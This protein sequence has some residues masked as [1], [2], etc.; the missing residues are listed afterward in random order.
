MQLAAEQSAREIER[1]PDAPAYNFS[2]IPNPRYVIKP[3]DRDETKTGLE[4]D[5]GAKASP[6]AG[7]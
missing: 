7:V 2:V 4:F 6:V 3:N 5:I 1:F